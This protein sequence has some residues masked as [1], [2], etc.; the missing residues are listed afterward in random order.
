MRHYKRLADGGKMPAIARV[1]Q[2]NCGGCNM[3]LPPQD[4]NQLIANP[5]EFRTCSNCSRIVYYRPPE[6]EEAVPGQDAPVPDEASAS[7]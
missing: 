6:E 5:G 1:E 4:Y 3:M 7:A 2:G